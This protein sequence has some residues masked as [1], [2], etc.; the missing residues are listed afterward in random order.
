LYLVHQVLLNES[1]ERVH[2]TIALGLMATIFYAAEP[3]DKLQELV[4]H[5]QP[6]AH[7]RSFLCNLVELVHTTLK[8]L[9]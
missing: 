2:Q 8:A 4:R 9:E 6:A 3:L 1:P 7:P 5:W